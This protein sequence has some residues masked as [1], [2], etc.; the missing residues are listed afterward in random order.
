[1]LLLGVPPLGLP[2]WRP[3]L[4]EPPSLASALPSWRAGFLP[5]EPLARCL[6][7]PPAGPLLGEQ[8]SCRAAAA[9]AASWRAASSNR[10][11]PPS[12]R[13]ASCPAASWRPLLPRRLLDASSPAALSPAALLLSNHRFLPPPLAEPPLRA[14]PAAPLPG[15]RLPRCGGLL[16]RRFLALGLCRCFL[17]CRFLA[18]GFALECL[19]PRRFQLLGFALERFLPHRL[20]P[21]RFLA[22]GRARSSSARCCASSACC[23]AS[24]AARSAASRSRSRSG[25]PCS[26]P[27]AHWRPRRWRA[28]AP[29]RPGR[30]RQ[31]GQF[32]SGWP[33]RENLRPLGFA[34]VRAAAAQEPAVVAGRRCRHGSRALPWPASAR[35]ARPGAVWRRC[36]LAGAG[37]RGGLARAFGASG[38]AAA[39]RA[40][41]R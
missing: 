30:R 23:S 12:C 40:R 26:P 24:R 13:A 37:A 4:G 9:R 15:V 35:A 31:R 2:P 16:P 28:R 36:R 29:R 5:S 20:L 7:L 8:A 19:L 17:P 34:V 18:L 1:M 21:R 27:A 41:P 32:R 25:V 38:S 3:P 10:F 22:A 33:A 6:P 14:L 11:L 39:C